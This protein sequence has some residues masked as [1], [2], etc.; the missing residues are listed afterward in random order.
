MIQSLRSSFLSL[1]LLGLFCLSGCH[2]AVSVEPQTVQPLS[3]LDSVDSACSYFYFLWGAHAELSNEYDESLQA[4]QKALVCDPGSEIIQNKIPLLLIKGGKKNEAMSYLYDQLQ[5][6]PA[7][8]D[9]RLV[10][11]RLFLQ[12]GKNDEAIELYKQVLKLEP[13][14]EDIL[15]RLGAIYSQQGDYDQ[16]KNIFHTLLQNNDKLYFGHIYL[17]RIYLQTNEPGNAQKHY[18]LALKLNWS[19]DLI[20]E[21]AAFYKVTNQHDEIVHIYEE[22]LLRSPYD[23]LAQYGL[24]E[25]LLNIGKEDTAIIQ[26]QEMRDFAKAPYTIDLLIGKIYISQK[27]TDKASLILK[28]LT[29][30]P[31]SSEAKFLLALINADINEEVSLEYLSEID[32]D[33]ND[34]ESAIF[35]Q[36]KIFTN[37]GR[38]NEAIATLN[39]HINNDEKRLPAMFSF[40]SAVYQN[41]EDPEKAIEALEDGVTYYPEDAELHFELALSYEQEGLHEQAIKTMIE[42]IALEPNHA[43]ALNFIGYVWADNNENLDSALI[44]IE[45]AHSLKPESGYIRDSLGWVYYK[46]GNLERA[47]SHL[48]AAATQ[49][50]DDPHIYHHLGDIYKDLK[51]FLEAKKAYQKA[52]ELT[53]D[54]GEKGKIQQKIDTLNAD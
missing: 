27:K 11:A 12:D 34:F 17:A 21:T 41:G 47:K 15:L 31:V 26:L 39:T 38:L 37:L 22:L 33:F 46:M 14:R 44:Y 50:V 53:E 40:L 6:N 49:K 10:L 9:E 54:E 5:D 52:L 13:D 2:K 3:A 19:A 1:F 42:V 32:N 18:A 48:E 43:E 16:A 24:I 23:E 45:K 30:S 35:L 25:A 28:S 29:N 8:I 36:A 4:Y 51:Y 7:G 20:H